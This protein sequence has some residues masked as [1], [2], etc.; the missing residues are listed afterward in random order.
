MKHYGDV[1]ALDGVDLRGA[2]GHGAGPA[3]PQRRR[4]DHGRPHPHHPAAPDAGRAEVAGL[5]VRRASPAR[6]ARAS[7]CPAST[8]RS[9]STSPASRT[10]TWSAGSTTWAAARPR[11]GPRELLER[12][13]LDRRRRPA[14]QDLL[15]RHAPP[16]RPR[17]RAGRRPAGAVPRRADH[18]PRPAQP[19]RHVGGHRRAGRRRHHAAAHHPV[20][21][22]GRPARRPAS[23]S[24]TTAGSSPQGT[25]DELKAQVGG[26]RLEIVVGP[27]AE[28]PRPPASCSAARPVGA[29]RGRRAH[30][31][32]LTAAG[33]A[34]APAVLIEALR[35]LDAARDRARR[36]RAAP[37]R[38]ST[39]SSSP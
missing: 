2:A 17:R 1:N 4:Q 12:F 36:R 25:A 6:C 23:S 39:T 19:H 32:R 13:D 15:R 33:H 20:P 31:G 26:E 14:G 21:R 3:R 18:R 9:T 22:G 16:A 29:G 8:P 10:S 5:D 7:G 28:L 11:R 37:A 38:R 30:A 27:A 35:R 34:A 24:S